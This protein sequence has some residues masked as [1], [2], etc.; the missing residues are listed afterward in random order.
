[1]NHIF[2]NIIINKKKHL[3]QGCNIFLF[4]GSWS[5]QIPLSV[6]EILIWGSH[7]IYAFI[8]RLQSYWLSGD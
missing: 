2:I 1:M 3:I 7:V 6:S 4:K 8:G 5:Q